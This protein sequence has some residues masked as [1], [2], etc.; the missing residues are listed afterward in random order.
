MKRLQI[1]LLAL[2]SV[3]II[4]CDQQQS[5]DGTNRRASSGAFR[6]DRIYIDS[7]PRGATVSLLPR[8][9]EKDEAVELGKTP[10]ELSPS[11]AP[12]MRFV[13]MMRMDDYIKAVE[14]LTPLKDWVARF[15]AQQQFGR[16]IGGQ[17]D[18]FDF[19]D[20]PESQVVVDPRGRLV[21]VGPVYTLE[22][23]RHHRLVAL[24]IPKRVKPSVFYSLMPPRGTFELDEREYGASLVADYHFSSEQR[25][26][27]VG[28]LSRCG[29]YVAKVK[30]TDGPD[31]ARLYSLSAQKG[32]YISSISVIRV[33]PGFNDDY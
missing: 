33:I 27:A 20:T 12:S 2:A 3:M 24:F 4:G 21:A 26:E 15:D 13:I 32:Y 22:W 23:P 5:A 19:E 18:Y 29:K 9:N 6:D 28:A 30:S 25:S 11:Q 10:L 16:S 1:A 17:Q 8:E 31:T 7:V 14:P